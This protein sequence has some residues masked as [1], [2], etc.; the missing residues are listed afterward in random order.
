MAE[1]GGE[2]NLAHDHEGASQVMTQGMQR[3][4]SMKALLESGAHFG[5]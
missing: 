2:C 5:H 1:P 3:L 4:V